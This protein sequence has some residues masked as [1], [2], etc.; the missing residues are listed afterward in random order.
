MAP[1]ISTSVKTTSTGSRTRKSRAPRSHPLLRQPHNHSPA[2]S[3]RSSSGP[4]PHLRRP[5]RHVGGSLRMPGT[6]ARSWPCVQISHH[7]NRF[8]D[9]TQETLLCPDRNL[10]RQGCSPAFAEE[11][12]ASDDLLRVV[13][14]LQRPIVT[15]IA[16]LAGSLSDSRR[17]NHIHETETVNAAG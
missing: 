13:W 14:L 6:G 17:Q 10:R 5:K 7:P 8:R 11:I 16:C 4:G 15:E 2:D 12:D 9:W 3:R 1:G